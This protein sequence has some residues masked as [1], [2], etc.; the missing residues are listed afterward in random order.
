MDPNA[1]LAEQ[2]EILKRRAEGDDTTE[3]LER[4]ADLALALDQW[5]C[6]GGFLPTEWQR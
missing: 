3:D 5:L 4:L 1:N 6:A 2:R